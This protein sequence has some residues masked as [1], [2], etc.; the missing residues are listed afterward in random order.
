MLSLPSGPLNR[1]WFHLLAWP[2]SWVYGLIMWLRNLAYDQGWLKSTSPSVPV[3][4]IGNLNAGGSGKT[5]HTETVAAYLHE[6]LGLI[7]ILSRGYG[8]R[9]KGF[10]L[11]GEG[12]NPGTLGDEAYMLFAKL[13]FVPLAVC[14]DRLEGLRQLQARFPNLKA[15][16]MDDGF[17]HRRLKPH[18]SFVLSDYSKPFFEDHLLPWGTL[19]E[20]WKG[21]RRANLVVFTKC[22]PTL[23]L[24]D[25]K[26][27]S[28]KIAGLSPDKV[29][30]SSIEHLD[31]VFMEPFEQR[32]LES[33]GH[34]L[35]VTGIA[36]PD[37]L[38]NHLNDQGLIYKHLCYEDHVEY[39]PERL[40]EILDA[41]RDL[42]GP[43][44]AIITTEKDLV[45]LAPHRDFFVQ[46]AMPLAYIP[47]QIE[48]P[49]RDR[50]LLVQ[51]LNAFVTQ[52][53]ERQ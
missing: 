39:T 11:A 46:H 6:S 21:Y 43:N 52:C 23:R 35:L 18:L 15:V 51:H 17:Q 28:G 42:H 49:E 9:T 3:V 48:F 20:P 10:H 26:Y 19:R 7:A 25:R 30:Y 16:V 12:D 33:Q 5:P 53:R 45:K 47:I 38:G 50:R 14:E 4:C 1:T 31:P 34:Y 29:L 13:P 22:P 24:Y 2:L 27:Y 32:P 44:R 8:R 37:L 40:D 41:F 36:N